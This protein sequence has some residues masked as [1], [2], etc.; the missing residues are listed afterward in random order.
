MVW[1]YRFI[2]TVYCSIRLG[3]TK[4]FGADFRLPGSA[5]PPEAPEAE[6]VKPLEEREDRDMDVESLELDETTEMATF[7]KNC[8]KRKTP[9]LCI[10]SANDF[11]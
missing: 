2:K 3:I 10:F 5:P 7:V 4:I 6:D 8:G 9:A 11:T 1:F